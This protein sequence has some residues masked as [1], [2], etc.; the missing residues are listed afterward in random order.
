MQWV[1]V[2]YAAGLL[3]LWLYCFYFLKKRHIKVK[4]LFKNS[5]AICVS[6]F[7][8]TY[9]AI[10]LSQLFELDIILDTVIKNLVFITAILMCYILLPRFKKTFGYLFKLNFFRALK[11]K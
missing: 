1:A 6:Y 11:Q 3:F 4:E 9:L 10:F 7:S 2:G 8:A 5:V